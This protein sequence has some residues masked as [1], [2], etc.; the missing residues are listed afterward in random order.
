[1]R[2]LAVTSGKGGVGKTN[3]SANLGIALSEAG[4]RVVVF[5]AD[6]GLANLD[7]VLGVKPAWTLQHVLAGEKKLHEIVGSGPG[8][9]GYI[10]GGSGVGAL[11]TL[12]G[13]EL[14][15]F[16]TD[17]VELELGTDILVFDTGAGVDNMVMTFLEA[18]D[19]TLLVTTPDPASI[20]DAYATAKML[21]ARKPTATIRVILN[22]VADQAHAKAVFAKIQTIS[23]QFLGK[24]LVYGGHIHSD[25]KA[26]ACIRSRRPFVLADPTCH[27]AQD[28][29]AIAAD[30]LGR[31][32]EAP[33]VRLSERLRSIFS[34]SVRRS[35]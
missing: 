23:Q 17:L 5:D 27:A 33:T 9:V 1:M 19:E 4:K 24:S 20:T 26:V 25:P 6:L 12:A 14:D 18:A 15:R 30:L 11:V 7:V 29:R 35:A 13:P 3:L 34:F 8:G 22:M 32:Y 16:L 2:T 10:A 28:V 21:W 31:E